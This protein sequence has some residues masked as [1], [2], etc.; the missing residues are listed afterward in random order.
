[1]YWLAP[2][3][4]QQQLLRL[5]LLLQL[6]QLPRVW[7]GS[8]ANLGMRAKLRSG[9]PAAL[10]QS[11]AGLLHPSHLQ[12]FE[13]LWQ[14]SCVLIWLLVA[15]AC[16]PAAAAAAGRAAAAAAALRLHSCFP[17][18][19]HADSW[20]LQRRVATGTAHMLRAAAD[21][22]QKGWLLA[23]SLLCCQYGCCCL[24]ELPLQDLLTW[25]LLAALVQTARLTSRC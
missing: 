4:Q 16:C 17:P 12:T 3:Q 21:A 18:L 10:L 19:L 20:A 9:A 14:L 6:Q 11:Q 7:P 1:V 22:V 25:T 15:A 23:A 2:Y 13:L 8:L 24:Q 5:L